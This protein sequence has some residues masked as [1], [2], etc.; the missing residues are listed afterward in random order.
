MD[1]TGEGHYYPVR[2]RRARETQVE[3][4]CPARRH[5]E[6]EA[7]LRFLLSVALQAEEGEEAPVDRAGGTQA[8]RVWK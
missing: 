2:E 7:M 4:V 6:R 8:A 1:T 3:Q 5:E